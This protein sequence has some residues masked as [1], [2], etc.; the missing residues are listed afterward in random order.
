MASQF[1]GDSSGGGGGDAHGDG[2]HREPQTA[3]W[4]SRQTAASS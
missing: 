1:S 2:D 3:V 4:I